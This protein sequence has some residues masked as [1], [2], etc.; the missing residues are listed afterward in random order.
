[1][2]LWR[3]LISMELC[4]V[5]LVLLCA[6]MGVG[7]FRLSGEYAAAINSVPLFVWLREVP[8]SISWWLWLTLVLL[9]LLAVNTVLCSG[10]TLWQRWGKSGWANLLA[11]Q[12]IHAGFLLIVLAHLLSALGAVHTSLEVREMTVAALPDGTPFGVAAISVTSTPQGMPLGYSS[13]LVPD[14]GNVAGRVTISPNHP[15]FAKGFGVYL[16][17][18]EQYPI[19][20]ALL[21][22]HHEPGASVALAGGILFTVGNLL[23]LAVR[24]KTR[25]M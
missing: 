8:T 18:A 14:L 6:A 2:K 4:L 7:S 16:K 12:L 19:K 15:W 17:H 5:L 24:S 9:V 3:F 25:E 22:I 1:M 21:E 10:E 20:R 13:E 11:P 23:L